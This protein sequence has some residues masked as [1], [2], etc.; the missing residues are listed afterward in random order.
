MHPSPCPAHMHLYRSASAAGWLTTPTV[1]GQPASL[2]VSLATTTTDTA[3]VTVTDTC[4]FNSSIDVEFRLYRQ[5]PAVRGEVGK[6]KFTRM[7]YLLS[8]TPSLEWSIIRVQC[9][10][11]RQCAGVASLCYR[12]LCHNGHA[13]ANMAHLLRGELTDSCLS[14]TA[15]P[16]LVTMS[17][18]SRSRRHV[19]DVDVDC[20]RLFI[21][22]PVNKDGLQIDDD[23]RVLTSTLVYDGC[24]VHVL[25]EFPDGYHLTSAPGYRLR[26]AGEFVQ[27]YGGHVNVVLGLLARLAASSAVSSEYARRTGA[28]CRLAGAFLSDLV[29]DTV[30][31]QPV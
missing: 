24:A 10:R 9:A 16:E 20:P 30:V 2:S 27:R 23:V 28:V 15:T 18:G 21:L 14:A 19:S 8:E 17:A 11:R 6:E 3:C 1:T 12:L 25:C 5:S 4:D 31:Q 7:A 29:A 22:L 13:T 26:R